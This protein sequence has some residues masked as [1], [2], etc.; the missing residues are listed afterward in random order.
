MPVPAPLDP[1]PAALVERLRLYA[2]AARTAP[3]K[4]NAQP[5]RFRVDGGAL[6]L[7]A[8]RSRLMPATDPDVLTRV[9]ALVHEV[10]RR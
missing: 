5:W 2:A 8:D 7:L 1:G 4:H 9:V 3:S 6:H 10:S